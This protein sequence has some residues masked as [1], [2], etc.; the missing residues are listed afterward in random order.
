ME[1]LGQGFPL[2]ELGT[3]NPDPQGVSEAQGG[4][5]PQCRT[6]T[7]RR[8]NA[9]TRLIRITGPPTLTPWRYPAVDTGHRLGHV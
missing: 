1:S 4:T 9:P 2:E 7:P 5:V 8:G 3:S 6:G